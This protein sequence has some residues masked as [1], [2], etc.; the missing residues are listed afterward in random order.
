ML[1][2]LAN[3]NSEIP[4]P[5]LC[6]SHQ[7]GDSAAVWDSLP[8]TRW[9]K[10]SLFGM[11]GTNTFQSGWKPVTQCWLVE[12]EN[13]SGN[14]SHLSLCQAD[15]SPSVPAGERPLLQERWGPDSEQYCC[16]WVKSLLVQGKQYKK[17]SYTVIWSSKGHDV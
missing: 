10:K 15:N 1:S 8:L 9:Q 5:T 13:V 11:S 14:T 16:S 4:P 6:P 3:C 7:P 17:L 2:C 12:M